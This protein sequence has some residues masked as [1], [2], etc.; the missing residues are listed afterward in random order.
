DDGSEVH[1]RLAVRAVRKFAVLPQRNAARGY[2]REV[3][4]PWNPRVEAPR[5]TPACRIHR[6][7]D[8]VGGT[9]VEVAAPQHRRS[10]E[11]KVVA[12]FG[13]LSQ[14]AGA[15]LP[16]DFQAVEVGPVD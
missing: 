13:I 2:L 12:G 3:E 15:K 9:E 11:G 14:L 5:F 7:G 8:T 6:E 16:G 1:A 4:V 10:F